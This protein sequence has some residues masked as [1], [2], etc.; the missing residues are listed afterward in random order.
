MLSIHEKKPDEA[1]QHFERALRSRRE[2]PLIFRNLA[3][4]NAAYGDLDGATAMLLPYV[5]A[6]PNDIEARLRLGMLL[7]ARGRAAEAV[8]QYQE[9]LR[10]QPDQP[11]VLNNLAWILATSA[12]TAARNGAEAVRHA[13]RACELT[14][15]RQALFLG[16]LAAAYAEAGRF[17]DATRTAQQ[18]MTEASAVG[19]TAIVDRNRQLLE[20][21]R[22]KK[23]FH[24]PAP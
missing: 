4:L 2:A 6:V 7:T 5:A 24:E 1:R 16:T 11:E 10:Q 15:R 3:M 22:T 19:Q 21:Y 8:Q 20:L 17:D 23:P 18:A 9:A 12:D 13:E 14:G